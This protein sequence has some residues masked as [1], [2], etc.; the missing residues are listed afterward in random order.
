MYDVDINNDGSWELLDQTGSI[1]IDVTSAAFNGGAGYPNGVIQIAVRNAISGSGNFETLSF[2]NT[3][4]DTKLTSIDQWGSTIT[5]TSMN[6]AF[7]GCSNMTLVAT[8][9]PDVSGVTSFSFAFGGCNL[10]NGDISGW[11]VSS[12]TNF[13]SMFINTTAFNQDIGNWNVANGTDFSYMFH[14]A[15]AFNGNISNWDVGN[16][17]HFTGMFANATS[18]NSDVSGW[19]VSS[20]Q[21][22][23]F[24]FSGATSFNQNIG[25]WNVANGTNFSAMFLNAS[26]FNQDIGNW[27]VA[28]GTSF[29]D[30]FRGANAFNQDIGGWDVGSGT[31]FISMFADASAFNQD[32][33]NWN[34]ANGTG[35]SNMFD[36][37]TAFDQDLGSWDLGSIISG[38]NMFD[39]SGFSV[40]NWDATL[41]GWNAQNFTTQNVTVGA[42]GL[43]Y[44]AGTA[45]RANMQGT[46]F[47]FTGDTQQSSNCNALATW[48]G[49]IDSDWDTAG[50]WD[51]NTVPGASNDVVIPSGLTNYP[52][53]GSA[54]SVNSVTMA[55][56]SSLIAN[57]TFSGDV[58]YNRTV[59]FVAGNLN[60]WYLM[61]APVSGQT[62]NDAYVIAN[63]IAANGT[64]RGIASYNTD[65]D[66]WSYLQSG[67][68]GTFNVGQGYSIKRG[69]STGDVSFSG[70]LNTDNAGVSVV[71]E[72][73]G[74][75][76]NLLGNPYTS[77]IDSNTFLSN[78]VAISDTQTLWVWN[79]T[80]GINGAYEV[81][82]ASDNFMIAPTQGFF[83]RS[84]T[85]GGTFTFDESNQSHHPT[86]TFL[87]N[88]QTSIRLTIESN[89]NS[90]YSR[91]LYTSNA[92]TGFDIGAE[93]ELF[94]GATSSFAIYTHLVSDSQGK[95]YQ[96]QSLPNTDFE[97][98]IIPI[99]IN[100]DA[101][102]EITI[103]AESL[104]LPAGINV[105]IED[106][107]N[108]TYSL[109]D[110]I[111]VFTTTL[112][113]D[114]NGIGR[115]YL[116]TKSEVLGINDIGLNRINIYTSDNKRLNIVGVREEQAKVEVYNILGQ[117][118]IKTS[119]TGNGFNTI[120]LKGLKRGLYVVRLI[121][122]QG[123]RNQKV[124]ID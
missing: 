73:T 36:T 77:Y 104:N 61:S 55:S 92:T 64:N 10:F 54:V 82:L 78:E 26:A 80:L 121:T 47:T 21:L 113:S 79:Q 43:Q 13:R 23:G 101:G 72:S 83:V 22:F 86:D 87:R 53:A 1:D 49:S 45:A 42:S 35:F 39:N 31:H 95:H 71:L 75:R 89:G 3:N 12:G 114:L 15:T 18:F 24:M 59:D 25:G 46:V 93:G 107:D 69:S 16:G 70:T 38:S 102:A 2:S 122:K 8:D 57:T 110:D 63:D 109:L 111:S 29:T 52:T 84:N 88:S 119:F 106:K 6:N 97:N 44:C 98:T 41:I 32:I 60:G 20:G 94:E 40:A 100:A 66:D 68:S 81:K 9:T 124:V 118:L 91:L 4:D 74:N 76:F 56:G 27:N 116:H 33:G 11:D 5:W 62:Y 105:Y 28:N 90:N 117:Q 19:D 120:S 85:E 48:T 103:S 58:T 50:N 30:M 14:T 37:A 34:V 123:E 65:N 96:V 51:I 108:D 99:G 115:F 112:T 67:G 7:N 17:T